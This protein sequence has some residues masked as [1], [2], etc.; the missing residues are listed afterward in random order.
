[1]KLKLFTPTRLNKPSISLYK[2]GEVRISPSLADIVGAKT[3][4]R[5]Q[6]F[7]DEEEPAD[8]YIKF[9]TD[10]G[11]LLRSKSGGGY[12]FCHRALVDAI[13]GSI[14]IRDGA[15]LS[16]PVSTDPD[17]EHGVYAILTSALK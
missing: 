14:K 4:T 5:I 13:K 9:N 12:N 2:N 8:W 1:M 10:D 16:M 7:Q 3:G 15:K 6:V 11:Y 17:P